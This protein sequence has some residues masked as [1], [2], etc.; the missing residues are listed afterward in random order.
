MV[1]SPVGQGHKVLTEIIG[2][3]HVLT[4]YRAGATHVGKLI[5]LPAA[6]T[7]C[8]GEKRWHHGMYA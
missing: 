3:H 4:I 2:A 7:Q 5:Y 1:E 6:H 8:N